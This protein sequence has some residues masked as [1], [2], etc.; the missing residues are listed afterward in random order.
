MSTRLFVFACAA[1]TAALFTIVKSDLVEADQCGDGDIVRSPM[2]LQLQQQKQLPALNLCVE[3]HLVPELFLIGAQKSATTCL[4]TE[5]SEGSSSIITPSKPGLPGWTLNTKE[6]HFFDREFQKGKQSWLS[7]YPPCP[8]YRAVAS[9]MTPMMQFLPVPARILQWYG[10]DAKHLTFVV[11]LRSPLHRMQSAFHHRQ[12]VEAAPKTDLQNRT[13]GM[14]FE[15]YVA[16]VLADPDYCPKRH[17]TGAPDEVDAFCDSLYVTQLTE[18]FARFSGSQFIVVPFKYVVARTNETRSVAEA[19]FRRL[20]IPGIHLPVI[21][22]QLGVSGDYG[23]V[24]EELSD[25]TLTK[26]QKLLWDLTGA[27]KVAKLLVQ[28]E[29]NLYKFVGQKTTDIT[30]WGKSGSSQTHEEAVM[31]WLSANW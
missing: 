25:D 4:S 17:I 27:D 2:L 24:A 28:H 29:A 31:D 20:G 13:L 26:L 8:S 7:H 3:N 23:P 5:L 15:Q 10:Q 6:P 21:A 18:W 30:L 12:K 16:H 14:S 22:G 1:V 9:D 19:L 11:L